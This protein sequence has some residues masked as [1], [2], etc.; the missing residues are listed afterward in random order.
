MAARQTTVWHEQVAL[1]GVLVEHEPMARHTTLGVGGPARWYFKPDSAE[2]IREALPLI[3]GELPRLPMGRGSNMLVLDAGFEGV[4][5]DLGNL[6]TIEV[7]GSRL[8]AGAGARMSKV[9][10]TCAESGLSGLEFLST[11]PGD[12]GGGVA[13]NA[14]AFGQEIADTLIHADILMPD[15]TPIRKS[16]AELNMTYRHSELPQGSLVTTAGFSLHLDSPEAI[17]ERIRGMREKRGRTQPL[18]QPNCGSVFKNPPGDYSARLIE[19]AGLKGYGI[20]AARIS[21]THAN[22]IVNEGG[23]SAA[24][25]IALIRKAQADVEAQAGI[26]LQPE[27]RIIGGES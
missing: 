24:D 16:R 5:I 10:R 9:A 15:G 26:R 17:R 12:M 20:G 13:M 3:P 1:H 7:D 6:D 8:T 21:E 14:G 27:V 19:S 18:S 11:V 4:V 22:F 2:A 25:V 23:A